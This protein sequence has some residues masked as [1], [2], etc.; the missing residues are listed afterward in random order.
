MLKS[1][2]IIGAGASGLV[3]AIV[4]ARNGAKVCVYEKNSK[5]GKKILATGNGRCN[6]TNKNIQTSNYHGLN[7]SFVNPAI[8][9]F[10]TSMC[11]DFFRELG[12][13]MFEGNN[14][15]LYPKSH[16][17]SSVVELL[18]YECNILGVEFLLNFEVDKITKENGKFAIF[19]AEN[20]KYA[21]K[22]LISTGGLAMPTLGSSDSGYKIAKTFGHSIISPCASL[23]QLECEDDLKSINGVK[24]EGNIEILVDGQ[25]VSKKNGDILFT[26]YGISGS[27]ILD[28]SRSAAKALE[29]Q[30]DVIAMLDL[31]PEYSKEQLK[32]ILIKRKKF[33]NKKS[34]EIWLD[35]F[36]NSK[37]AKFIAKDF[38][39]KKA[40]DL[41][42]KDI[43][44]LVYLFKNMK[45]K[46]TGT[47][48]FKSAEV[49]AGGINT[50]EIN[51][52][53]ME[54]KF[55][56]G[57]FFSGEVLDIDGDCGGYNL[58]WAWASGYTVGKNI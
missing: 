49:T 10:N 40:D 53:T 44:R 38:P 18:A 51:A 57:L 13:E 43:V 5:I 3:A 41:N 33:S 36:I 15:R 37:L 32:N 6:I 30:R 45:L 2:A 21:D 46:V 22:V 35:G 47:R 54:S 58:H 7:S 52:Q 27:A 19:S 55:Q 42:T 29:F 34:L 26:N 28:V 20:K 16:Q 14:G 39:V 31:I 23:V 25:S 4:A 8:N 11:I 48:G 24:I 17:S 12:I 9:K 50:D 56:K 1:V